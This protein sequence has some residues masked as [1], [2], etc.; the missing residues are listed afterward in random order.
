MVEGRKEK[1]SSSEAG[2]KESEKRGLRHVARSKQGRGEREKC[3]NWWKKGV[4]Q[5]LKVERRERAQ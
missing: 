2:K 1:E 5:W 4:E 3:G